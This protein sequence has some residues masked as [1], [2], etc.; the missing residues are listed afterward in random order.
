MPV[1]RAPCAALSP[2][3]CTFKEHSWRLASEQDKRGSRSRLQ[4]RVQHLRCVHA[5]SDAGRL[6]GLHALLADGV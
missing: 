3:A 6:N 1:L 2:V 5:S 4:P